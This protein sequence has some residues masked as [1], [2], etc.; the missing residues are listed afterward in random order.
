MKQKR[1]LLSAGVLLILLCIVP[2]LAH[3]QAGKNDPTFNTFDKGGDDP[4]GANGRV[5][6]SLLL[7]DGKIMIGG[8]F[9]AYNGKSSQGIAR[10]NID[11]S[12]DQTFHSGLTAGDVVSAIVVQENNKLIISGNFK[13]Y[14]GKPANGIAR[15]NKN[16]SLDNTFKTG[17]GAD[18]AIENIALQKNGKLVVQGNFSTY[19]NI[20]RNRIARL[21]PNG[22]LD[23][24]FIY[25]D[26]TN[27]RP[28]NIA[29]Q[30]DDKIIVIFQDYGTND[31]LF[32]RLNPNG[33]IDP[34]F[35]APKKGSARISLNAAAIQ[36]DGEIVVGGISSSG[37]DAV[38]GYARR[39]DANGTMDENFNPNLSGRVYSISIQN[40]G[41]IIFAG[42]YKN[43]YLMK[44]YW[45]N[46]IQRINPDGSNDDSFHEKISYKGIYFENHTTAIQ[47]DGRIILGGYF[48]HGQNNVTRLNEDGSID[49][50]FNKVTGA[51]GN[52]QNMVLQPNG[53]ILISGNFSSYNYTSCNSLAR[54]NT[55]GKLDTKFN[56]GKGVNG[57]I[58]CIAVQPDKKVVIAGEFTNYNGTTCGNVIRL[59]ETG[60]VD[61]TLK[62]ITNGKVVS[63]DLQ[64]DHKIIIAGSFTS[65]NGSPANAIV[66]VSK[67]GTIDPTFVLDSKIS[68]GYIRAKLQ[69]DG[70]ILI[71]TYYGIHRLNADGS[72]DS[73]FKTNTWFENI[74]IITLQDDGKIVVGGNNTVWNDRGFV[75]R[76]NPNGT[77][78]STFADTRDFGRVASITVLSNGKLIV[79]EGESV[80]RLNA[81]GT[82]D[83]TA[84]A[85][86]PGA[87]A[88]VWCAAETDD[89]KILI[90]G[91]FTFYGGAHR[92]GIAR[93]APEVPCRAEQAA[94]LISEDVTSQ[95]TI[96]VY[97]N[98]V[99][100]NL[101]IS[102]LNAGSSI[103]VLNALGE[104][105]D[106]KVAQSE[107]LT[108]ETSNYANGIYF[109][110][111]LQN[112]TVTNTKF[113]VN[114]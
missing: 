40:D 73:T 101:T 103:I 99:T 91:D 23:L 26:S 41:K 15:L 96:L 7:P 97:P 59:H 46:T 105:M 70:K 17:L 3:A 32:T 22:K 20:K 9:S 69:D 109:I 85:E 16:G 78:D 5:L 57:A 21:N 4:K 80:K 68:S 51:N 102:N 50:S 48:Q 49:L 47:L 90:G 72:L 65:C 25:E 8:T 42:M 84:E 111:T 82:I 12:L 29:L 19:N 61:L 52:V 87:N 37:L 89:G 27:A 71:A 94:D 74:E 92:N 62:A 10:L 110:R 81:D 83:S 66:R 11:G 54:L 113:I 31:N 53:K 28:G 63:I 76:L 14:K 2:A 33:E 106:E 38:Y 108:I 77:L 112:G 56:S 64:P 67:N 100:N 30:K 6:T 60:T 75:V 34:S 104:R 39:F 98:P 88:Q 93:I 36:E 114:K 107:R 55:N 58:H 35:N 79:G 45:S 44:P 86:G 43:V 95:L 13:K 1:Y 24:T 18:G